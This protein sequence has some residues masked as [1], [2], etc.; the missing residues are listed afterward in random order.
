MTVSAE[1]VSHRYGARVAL[2]HVCLEFPAG[3]MA[4]LIGPDGVGKSTLLG[5]IRGAPTLQQGTVRAFGGDMA[6]A[7]HRAAIRPRIAYMPQGLRRNLYPTLSVFENITSWATFVMPCAT[8]RS[9][10]SKWSAYAGAAGRG[11]AVGADSAEVRQKLAEHRA[12]RSE[13]VGEL[14]GLREQRGRLAG[15]AAH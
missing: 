9:L 4:G 2:D 10:S 8:S 14:A 6:N 11:T 1:H 7:A 13:L 5:L 12:R 15:R 3:R